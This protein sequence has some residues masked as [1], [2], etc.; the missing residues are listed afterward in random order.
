MSMAVKSKVRTRTKTHPCHEQRGTGH[1]RAECG[2]DAPERRLARSGTP[3]AALAVTGLPR[4]ARH[5]SDPVARPLVACPSIGRVP[6][7]A[8]H[9]TA[10]IVAFVGALRNAIARNASVGGTIARI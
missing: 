5:V 10:V 2:A 7:R 6:A 3:V 9:A 8:G 1:Q 4:I